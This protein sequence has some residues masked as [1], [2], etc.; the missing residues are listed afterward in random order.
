MFGNLDE[1]ALRPHLPRECASGS[2]RRRRSVLLEGGQNIAREG[3]DVEPGAHHVLTAPHNH[4]IA[5]GHDDNILTAI[6]PR[7]EGV[8]GDTFKR[9]AF[10]PPKR[11]PA[12]AV[13]P[14]APLRLWAAGV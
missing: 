4:D 7:G 8:V 9:I 11:P 14:L 6:A 10:R 12:R 2:L 5:A 3:G 13:A 1:R